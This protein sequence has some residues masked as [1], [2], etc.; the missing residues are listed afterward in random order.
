MNVTLKE[1]VIPMTP[2]MTQVLTALAFRPMYVYGLIGQC[3]Y[4]SRGAL[5]P[6]LGSI[7]KMMERLRVMG[8][9]SSRG[10][11]PTH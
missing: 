1:E 6:G 5:I 4:D 3:E 11:R 7:Y 2:Q 9:V 10:H 8:M